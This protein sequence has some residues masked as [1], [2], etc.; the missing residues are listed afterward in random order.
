MN[1]SEKHKITELPEDEARKS[2]HV[3]STVVYAGVF[4]NVWG[5]F[6]TDST[7]MLWF[8]RSKDYTENLSGC[9]I[10]YV[11]M[12]GFKLKGNHRRFIE[13]LGLN[14]EK[15]IPV[16]ELTRYDSII[17]PDEAFFYMEG[18][19]FF[20]DAYRAMIDEV[21]DFAEN[22]CKPSDKKKV[23]YSYAGY[24][25]GKT[26][27]EDKLERYFVSKGYEIVHPEKLSLDEQLNILINCESFASTLG[28]CSHNML[29]L[30]DDTEVI[31]IP[32]SNYM[33]GYQET[34]N[35]LHTQRISYVDA[36]FSVFTNE[37]PWCGPFLYFVSSN[38]RKYFHDEDTSAI[39]DVSDFMRYLKANPY[40]SNPDAYKYYS[41]I[42]SE[43]FSQL[44]TLRKNRSIRGK[45]KRISWLRN[46]VR[47]VKK[48]LKFK[49]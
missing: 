45:L 44:F 22:N 5:H 10:V 18:A 20:T 36:S 8:L 31:L 19:R 29:F 47:A 11:P 2:K 9:L 17:V 28:S 49:R 35:Q 7:K 23:Y 27:G 40:A 3:H 14:P 42:A 25:N 24:R 12:A 6:I 4:C 33:N 21:R 16:N 30:R 38:L 34:I 13:I 26:F 32:R 15:F 1:N 46:A 41:V 43:Y 37:F 48:F 39:I